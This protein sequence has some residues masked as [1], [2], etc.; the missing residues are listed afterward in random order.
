M[1]MWELVVDELGYPA[2]QTRT[3]RLP[4]L[5]PRLEATGYPSERGMEVVRWT[6][7]AKRA[8]ARSK[9]VKSYRAGQKLRSAA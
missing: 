1:S 5:A 2:E 8:A 3:Y 9:W 7:R 6:R 4:P